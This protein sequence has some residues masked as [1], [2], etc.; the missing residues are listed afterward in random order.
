MKAWVKNVG[1]KFFHSNPEIFEGRVQG[2][3]KT[4]CEPVPVPDVNNP[5]TIQSV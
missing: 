3:G 4:K 1:G 5:D 2:I